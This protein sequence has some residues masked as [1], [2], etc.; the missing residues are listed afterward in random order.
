MVLRQFTIAALL[1]L[2][3]LLGANCTPPV[4]AAEVCERKL[5]GALEY[6]QFILNS[7]H[8]TET[9]LANV[10]ALAKRLQREVESL[11]AKLKDKEASGDDE[12]EPTGTK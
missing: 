7:R 3:V 9:R 5:E 8:E 2:L 12:V 4:E 6:G 10:T 11:K 1:S